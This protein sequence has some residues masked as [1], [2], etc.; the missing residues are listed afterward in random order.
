MKTSPPFTLGEVFIFK[1]RRLEE[2]LQMDFYKHRPFCNVRPCGLP[3][4]AGAA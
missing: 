3:K 1:G 4:E 2:P